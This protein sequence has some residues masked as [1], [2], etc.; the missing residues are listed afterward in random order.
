MSRRGEGSLFIGRLSKA[1]RVRD[2]EDVFE[3]Y[4]RMTRCEVKYGYGFVDFEDRRDAEDALRYE[5]GRDIC[6][7]SIIVEWAKG[8]PRRAPARGSYDDYR[9]RRGGQFGRDYPDDRYGGGG[10]RRRGGRYRSPSPRRRR[11]NGIV[12]ERSDKWNAALDMLQ[13]DLNTAA[14]PPYE[15]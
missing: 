11:R 8:N 12:L 6:G 4:G 10:G 5:N 7:S 1:T 9:G 3:P 13:Q 14:S 15:A 2:V